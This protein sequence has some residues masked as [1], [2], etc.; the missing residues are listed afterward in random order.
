MSRRR[1]FL[2]AITRQTAQDM[3]LEKYP[4]GQYVQPDGA[5][6]VRYSG[7]NGSGSDFSISVKCALG[8]SLR[9]TA[10]LPQCTAQSARFS[11]CVH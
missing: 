2:G 10:S 4:N 3:L 11:F 1:W 7:Q 5:F 8:L 9:L 6:L